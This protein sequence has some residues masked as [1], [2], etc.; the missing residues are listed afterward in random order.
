MGS[1]LRFHSY[2]DIRVPALGWDWVVCIVWK[3]SSLLST[4]MLNRGSWPKIL[5]PFW[6]C[7]AH[8]SSRLTSRHLAMLVAAAC[9]S[10]QGSSTLSLL[11]R[12]LHL[13]L[14]LQSEAEVN[15]T[16][17]NTVLSRVLTTVCTLQVGHKIISY[18]SWLYLCTSSPRGKPCQQCRTYWHH[19]KANKWK[20]VRQVA[21][22]PS[23]CVCGRGC[24]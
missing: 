2:T 18:H 4:W 16:T 19:S 7:S 12:H 6:Q 10:S 8:P 1:I 13:S 23:I 24:H 5:P 15:M 17:H 20:S 21:K 9:F 22:Y 3:S 11:Q 14:Q